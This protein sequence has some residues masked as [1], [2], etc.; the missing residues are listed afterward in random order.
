M[1]SQR[2]SFFFLPDFENWLFLGVAPSI[3][4]CLTHRLGD[5]ITVWVSAPS[6][7]DDSRIAN[8][9]A[10]YSV[11]LR[12]C[13]FNTLPMSLCSSYTAPQI[14]HVPK[15]PPFFPIQTS[16]WTWQTQLQVAIL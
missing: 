12:A 4:S 6:L 16:P 10:T 13:A 5:L 3:L 9:S 1:K 8:L 7:N 11:E 14:R 15:R 2:D